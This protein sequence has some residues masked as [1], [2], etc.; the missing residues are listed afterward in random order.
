MGISADIIA[1]LDDFAFELFSRGA[2]TFT[3]DSVS[4]C[5]KQAIPGLAEKKSREMLNFLMDR[6]RFL[7]PLP[8]N[9]AMFFHQSVTEFLAAVSLA[10]CGGSWLQI[11]LRIYGGIRY[12]CLQP[13]SLKGR[14][15]WNT[16]P[17]FLEQTAFWLARQRN[18]CRAGALNA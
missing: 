5:M 17:S 16:F 10:S 11:I 3:L 12:F 2:E 18:M 7:V 8:E 15:H 6:C 13:D 4:D 9:R 14:M 1:A